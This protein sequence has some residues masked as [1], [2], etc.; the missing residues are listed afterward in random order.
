MTTKRQLSDEER[1]INESQILRLKEELD[2]ATFQIN[3]ADLM[4]N[5]GLLENF[6]LK[7]KEYIQK[8]RESVSKVQENTQLI[9][10]L[11]DQNNNGVDLKDS[12]LTEE[13]VGDD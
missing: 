10:I 7:Q 5:Q 6:K 11:E 9:S 13:V 4:L 8:K 12:V 1:K 2:Y 3:Y